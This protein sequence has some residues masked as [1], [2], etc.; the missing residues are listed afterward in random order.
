MH[1]ANEPKPLWEKT[2]GRYGGVV[3]ALHHY[4]IF[5]EGP[6]DTFAR[7]IGTM[8]RVETMRGM[9]ELIGMPWA[10]YSSRSLGPV[11]PV[12]L[13]ILNVRMFVLSTMYVCL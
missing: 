11:Q 1:H 4:F 10:L 9:K 7:I 12:T 13:H 3:Y 6:H 5:C 8:E 2:D